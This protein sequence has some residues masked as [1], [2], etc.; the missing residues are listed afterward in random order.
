MAQHVERPIIMPLSNPTSK[1][2]CTP[3]EAIRWTDGRAIVATGSPFDPVQHN[4]QT[5]VAGQANNVFIFPGVGLGAILSQAH[6]VTD[7]M[8]LAAAKTL[9]D[10]VDEQRLAAGAVYPCQSKLR[11]VS[12]RIAAAVM[13]Q[14]RA[15]GVGRLM[16]DDAIEPLIRKSMWFPEYLPYVYKG[17]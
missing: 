6:Q 8:F 3:E 7:N 5:H 15:D 16:H 11:E 1:A 17:N 13:R 2:E 14:A 12:A 9:A 10:C 4:G